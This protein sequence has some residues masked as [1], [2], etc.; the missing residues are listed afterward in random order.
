VFSRHR[1]DWKCARL[2]RTQTFQM[3]SL[4]FSYCVRLN[5][6]LLQIQFYFTRA[7][8]NRNIKLNRIRNDFPLYFVK[9]TPWLYALP[10]FVLNLG[11]MTKRNG[12]RP[13]WS[14]NC[15][16]SCSI[17]TKIP[18][19]QVCLFVTCTLHNLSDFILFLIIQIC[20]RIEILEE[21]IAFHVCYEHFT[22]CIIY[23]SF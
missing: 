20:K 10:S 7:N 2:R 11:S 13:T 4:L 1:Q 18:T 5:V 23:L 3:R 16:P 17:N 14:E 12:K 19:W 21:K 6:H 8:D 22:L 15:Y 9:N